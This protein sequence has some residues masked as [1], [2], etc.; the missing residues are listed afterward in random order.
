ME[1]SWEHGKFSKRK[2]WDPNKSVWGVGNVFRKSK[3]GTAYSGKTGRQ[4]Y[5]I[6]DKH[7]FWASCNK[8]R[9]TVVSHSFVES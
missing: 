2:N 5:E 1:I 7:V 4:Q 3:W 6:E 8:L 9:L